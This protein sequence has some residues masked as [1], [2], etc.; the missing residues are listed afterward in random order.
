M[1][2]LR[3]PLALALAPYRPCWPIVALA[4][5]AG[6]A[7]VGWGSW[8]LA[9]GITRPISALDEAARRLQRGE[10]AQVEI[11]TADE[12]GRLAGSFNTMAT[13]IRDRERR[14]THLALHDGETGLPNR[15]AL[16][17]VVEALADLPPRP[18]LCRRPRRRPLR[19]PA[20]RHRL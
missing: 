20:R 12:I 3:Y 14:I 9:R 17:R 11:E 10:D 18:G 1:L 4:G 19:P 8:V 13:E 16:E 7:V 2:L 6:L 5:L 15:L